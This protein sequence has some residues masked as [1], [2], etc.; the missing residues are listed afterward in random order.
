[1]YSVTMSAQVLI[2]VLFLAAS[3]MAFSAAH[4]DL[5]A[6][7]RCETIFIYIVQGVT[8]NLDYSYRTRGLRDRRVEVVEQNLDANRVGLVHDQLRAA[9]RREQIEFNDPPLHA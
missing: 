6:C 1:M 5:S 2:Q 4:I 7:A 3:G 9:L 8:G